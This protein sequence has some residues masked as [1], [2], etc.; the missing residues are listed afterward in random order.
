MDST[1]SPTLILR[2]LHTLVDRPY[3][4]MEL[5]P[6]R[7]SFREPLTYYERTIF[8][9]IGPY[10]TDQASVVYD[11]GAHR[12]DY[13][14]VFA[15]AKNV[16]TV[17]SF[18]PIPDVFEELRTRLAKFRHAR[19]FNT[20]LG[21]ATSTAAFYRNEHSSSSSLLPMKN[22]HK[23]LFPFTEREQQITV[24]IARLD[25]LVQELALPDPDLVKIDVQGFED[26]VIAGGAKAIKACHV[27]VVEVSL[28]PL[29]E[30]AKSF[31][32][33]FAIMK[34]LGFVVGGIGGATPAPSGHQA[35]VDVV[36]CRDHL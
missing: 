26:R 17:I 8:R 18:E 12:G 15:K 36:F 11:I 19:C 21:D 23:T 30:D 29:Y 6:F 25:D 9:H 1:S 22:L 14:L 33:I 32:E 24:P 34:D 27:C 7:K 20:A 3:S 35:Q 13:S 28:M 2:K 31:E 16:D 10:L 5:R 4:A